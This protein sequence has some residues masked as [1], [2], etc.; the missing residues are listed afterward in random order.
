MFDHL[1]DPSPFDPDDRFRAAVRS[2]ADR[3]RTRR[4][5]ALAAGACGVTLA[6]TSG[7]VLTNR[8]GDDRSDGV[9]TVGTGGTASGE[10]GDSAA[11]ATGQP[12]T[13]AAATAL[14]ADTP[15]NILL[16]GSDNRDCI[17]PE[18]P[19][20]GAYLGDGTASGGERSDTMMILRLEPATQAT[21]ILSFPRDLWVKI[22]G[23]NGK[24]RINAAFDSQNPRKLVDTI[25]LNFGI[26]VDHYV[27]VDFCAFEDI[28]DVIGGVRVPFE[29]AARD[30]KTGLDI[31]GP[32]CH[33]FGGD[34][35]LAYVR[36]R[37][38]QWF[39]PAKQQWIT[40]G[41]GDL[42]RISR[43][44][45]FMRRAIGRVLDR[46]GRDPLAAKRL[47]DA[48]VRDVTTDT[49][50]T[51]DGLL[52]LFGAMQN[53]DPAATSM[54]QIEGRGVMRGNASVLEPILDSPN[55]QAVLARFGGVTPAR[56]DATD[57]TDPSGPS[58]TAATPPIIGDVRGIVPPYDPTCR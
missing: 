23:T 52:G 30:K 48:T 10:S 29:Y 44:Q 49:G 15:V 2:R 45:D 57:T 18:S 31:A 55:M 24:G 53:A 34:E 58:A 16:T 20:A 50:L 43:Q 33:A 12:T 17:D 8:L 38:Y 19:Y 40:D 26:P 42:G 41:T 14:A 6:V 47:L 27:N 25:A 37:H 7:L 28:V 35:A 36:S 4:R 22:A 11:P 32:E 39:D 9:R 21:A 13:T 3:H 56:T 1:D 5:T 54:V 46:V 51:I